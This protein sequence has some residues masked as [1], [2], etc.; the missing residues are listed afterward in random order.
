MMTHGMLKTLQHVTFDHQSKRLLVKKP[1]QKHQP[2]L[3]KKNNP[4]CIR[5]VKINLSQKSKGIFLPLSFWGTLWFEN[6]VIIIM[7]PTTLA[8]ISCI[9]PMS[10]HRKLQ[11]NILFKSQNQKWNYLHKIAIVFTPIII[12][13]R[14]AYKID[15]SLVFIQNQIGW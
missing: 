3:G 11:L 9:L 12:K 14:H 1:S 8:T 15:P 13:T 7:K 6:L 4:N 10:T 2:R 5:L